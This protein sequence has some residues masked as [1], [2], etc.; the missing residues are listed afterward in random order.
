[1]SNDLT[2]YN[3]RFQEL[4]LLCTKMVPKEEDKVEKYIGGLLDNIEGNV[5]ATEPTRLQD[6]IRI[7]NNLMDQKLKGYAIKNAENKRRAYTV[8]NNVKRIWYVGALPYCSKCRLHHEGPCMV[9]CG[10]YKR[11]GHMT[12]DCKAAVATTPQRALIVRIPYGDEM[13]IIEGDG[14]NGGN[15]KSE[16]KRLEDVLIVRDFPEVFP[17]DLPGLPPTRQVEYQIDLVPDAAPNKKE[18]EG[19]L[20]LILR[21]LK[22]EKLF[23]KFSKCEFWLSKVKFLSHVIDSECI[24]IDHAKIESVKDWASP[25]TPTKIQKAEAAFQVLKQKLCSA[26]ILALTEGSENFVVY[27]DASHKGLDAVLMQR[28]KVIAYASHQLKLPNTT[29]S[30]DTIWVIVD[31]LTMSA[32]FLPMREDD[33]LEKLT[34]QYLKEVV[35]THGV[36]VLIISDEMADSLHTFGAWDRHLLLVEFLYNNT[37]HTSNR[38]APFEALYG[39]KCQSPICWA[40]VG[41]SKLPGPEIIYEITEKIVQIK[42]HIQAARDCQKSYT[43]VRRIPLEFQVR[44]KVMLKV[45]P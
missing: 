24:H 39:R 2:A 23:T 31:H 35:S 5:I 22:E 20:K 28:E 4:T 12:R 6:A 43:D 21:L 7:A 42:R 41:D 10:Y 14:C 17:E 38:A 13:L 34:R 1:K 40:K 36:S 44:D 18:H 30:Q 45:S 37:Y 9:K 11:V 27:Y 25:K 33:S 8:R 32:H 29:T 26:P 3:Q 15:D 19:H 16:E